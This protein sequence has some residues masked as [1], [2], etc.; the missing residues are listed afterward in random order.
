[1]LDVAGLRHPT[2]GSRFALACVASSAIVALAV[3]ALVALGQEARLALTILGLAVFVLSLLLAISLYRIRLLADAVRVSTASLPALQ[4]V[5]DEVRQRLGYDGRLTVFVVDKVDRVLARTVTPVALT[6]YFGIHV[7]VVEGAVVGDLAV[8]RERQKLVFLL[9]TQV[10]ALKA[11]Q[12]TWT[13]VL[14]ALLYSGIGRLATPFILPWQRATVY[15]GDRFALACCGDLEVSLESAY[16]ALVGKEIAPSV[17]AEGLVEQALVVRRSV[18]LRIVQLMRSTPH[19][20]NRYLELLSFSSASQPEAYDAFHAAVG[21]P[22]Q[23]VGAVVARLRERRPHDAA[24]PFG[25]VL[26]GLLLTAGIVLGV[27]ARNPGGPEA[28][29]GPIGPVITT[30]SPTVDPV[31]TPTPTPTPVETTASTLALGYLILLLPTDLQASCREIEPLASG[32]TSVAA[33]A[34]VTCVPTENGGPATVQYYRFD[35]AEVMRSAFDEWTKS[36]AEGDCVTDGDGK[37]SWESGG[38]AQGP[39][40]C[41]AGQ[42]DNRVILWGYDAEGVLAVAYDE[43]LSGPELYEWWRH[44]PALAS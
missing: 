44:V 1:M 5:V 35:G 19:A 41:Y 32:V 20:T 3:A 29:I 10:G 2:E 40:A 17:R 36:L 9:A 22:A 16:K 18:V 27:A 12:T 28:D 8:P 14:A 26:S 42:G 38:T 24:L 7:I 43:D 31:V 25:L 34:A 39:L 21:R 13:P 33:V 30:A 15:S 23:E 6:S 37:S 4:S 11:K